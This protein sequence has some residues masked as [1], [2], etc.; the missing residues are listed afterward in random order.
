MAVYDKIK[1]ETT[2]PTWKCVWSRTPFRQN[3]GGNE[4]WYNDIVISSRLQ[5]GMTVD[6]GS[7]DV[8]FARGWVV[9]VAKS[10]HGVTPV[11]TRHGV[12]VPA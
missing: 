7:L 5:H 9:Q 8:P 2:F 4:G 11:V 6:E 12:R 1:S 3:H 10:L